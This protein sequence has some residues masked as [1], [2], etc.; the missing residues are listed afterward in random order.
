MQLFLMFFLSQPVGMGVDMF[1]VRAILIPAAIFS[2]GGLIALSFAT[3][4]WQIF[5]AQSLCFGLGAAG[6]FIPGLVA[7]GQYFKKKRALVMGIV[8]S[9]SSCGGVVFPIMLARLF[10][11]I[12]FR[13]TLRYTALMIGIM[14]AIANLLVTSPLPPKGLAGR[15][16]LISFATFKKPAYLLFVSGSFLFFWGLF[17][18]FDYLPIFAS[19]NPKTEHIALY[20]VAILK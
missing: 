14:L 10:D 16:T 19:M 17:G 20:T 15:K 8:A 6:T 9:G 12:G 11:Q 13:Q 1:G 4:Y 18:P 7:A 5:L 3:E 2:V